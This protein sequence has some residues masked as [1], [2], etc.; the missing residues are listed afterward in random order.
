MSSPADINYGSL[1]KIDRRKTDPI[2]LQIAYQFINAIKRNLLEDG[3]LLPGSRALAADLHIHRKTVL[4]ACNELIDQGWLEVI[5]NKG[6][7]VRNPQESEKRGISRRSTALPPDKAPFRF[8]KE[9]ILES[10]VDYQPE[11]LYFTDGSPDHR[12]IGADELVR[13]YASVLKRKKRPAEILPGSDNNYF[14]REQ[15]AY[16][17]NLTRG[18]HVSR[19]VI[20]PAAGRELIF[21][22]LARL[23]LSP[24]D[25]VLVEELS[26][27]LPNMVF[28]Q[29][30][31]HLKTIPIDAEGMNITHIRKHFKP[32][33][34]RFIYLNS[35]CQYPTT[36]TLSESRRNALLELAEEYD[37]IIIEDDA[38][39]ENTGPKSKNHSLFKMDSTGRVIYTGAFGSFLHPGF[40]SNF[41][42]GPVDLI[43]EGMKYLNIFG[44]P[45]FMLEKALGEMI[46]QGDIMR[47]QRKHSKV[48]SERRELFAILLKQHFKDNITFKIPNQGTAFWIIFKVRFSMRRLQELAR[49]RGLLIPRVCLYQNRSVTALRLGFAHL[50]PLEMEE[51]VRIL[52]GVWQDIRDVRGDMH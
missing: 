11:G 13:F 46:F 5:P 15:L 19:K 9:I 48:L 36:V 7:Y 23:L 51:S 43:E 27:F 2:Y 41:L 3:D 32:S 30:G 21:S 1:I 8:R 6:T 16:Y 45:D 50:T 24:G 25:I 12:T 18:F 28:S 22:I 42:L 26:Y 31:A 49:Q 44:K 39:S 34:I 33:N 47:Y 20:L 38:D 35:G 14:F 17:L 40:R 4:A 29:A 52:A 10:P 37:L